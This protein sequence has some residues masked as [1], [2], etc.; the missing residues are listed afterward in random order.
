MAKKKENVTLPEPA[1]TLA[2]DHIAVFGARA[3]NLKNLDLQL[4]KN[5]LVVFTGISGRGKSS[6]E[7][8]TIYADGQRRYM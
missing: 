8:D 4:P 6:L 1:P 2:D 5:K 7:F 3:H